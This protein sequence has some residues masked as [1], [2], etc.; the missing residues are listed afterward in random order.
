MTFILYQ[1]R[2]RRRPV[3]GVAPDP[4]TSSVLA[5]TPI[6]EDI[7]VAVLTAVARDAAGRPVV[8]VPVIFMAS[9]SGNT[10]TQS[11]RPTDVNGVVT[12][13]FESSVA[14]VKT[15][16]AIAGGVLLVATATVVVQDT[17]VASGPLGI[18][19]L[20]PPL[21]LPARAQP[22]P[23]VVQGTVAPGGADLLIET[24]ADSNFASRDWYDIDTTDRVASPAPAGMPGSMR[25]TWA[26]GNSSPSTLPLRKLFTASDRIYLRYQLQCSANWVG[27]GVSFHPHLMTIQSDADDDFNG[28][29]DANLSVYSEPWFS[30][31]NGNCLRGIFQD[32]RVIDP[33]HV[34]SLGADQNRSTSGANGQQ[35]D[36]DIWDVFPDAA[37]SQGYWN[38]RE[39]LS[40]ALMAVG[41]TAWHTVVMEVVLNSIS[42][43]A[44]LLD[45]VCRAWFDGKLIWNHTN[46][47]MRTG[48]QPT[49]KLNQFM[50]NPYIEG[51]SPVTQSLY[52]GDLTVRTGPGAVTNLAVSTQP[53]GAVD[54]V[55][56]TTQPT[57]QLRDAANRPVPQS[58]TTITA[59]LLSGSGA[60]I[61]T[62]TAVTNSGGEAAFTNLGV[63]ATSPPSSHTLRF[64][65]GAMTVDSSS[66][67]VAAGGGGGAVWLGNLPGS[68]AQYTSRPFSAIDELSWADDSEVSSPTLTSDA[69]APQ[70]PS[71]VGLFTYGAGFGAGSAPWL[72]AFALPGGKGLFTTFWAWW[73]SNFQGESS[74][75]NKIIFTDSSSTGTAGET[76]LSA[77]GVGS[78]QLV[79]RPRLQNGLDA[80]EHLTTN[81]GGSDVLTR[82]QWHLIE[83]EQIIGTGANGTW[84]AWLNGALTHSYTNVNYGTGVWETL[85]VYPIWGGTGGSVGSSQ[86]LRIDQLAAFGNA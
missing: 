63:N 62:A 49:K 22:R 86:N 11:V 74:G 20:P 26:A 45:G 32:N 70:S 19:R 38:S 68:Y 10:I 83:I 65:A 5:Q 8:G 40:S 81:Q 79:L 51:G 44:P 36:A 7:G 75:T 2:G 4:L 17:Y 52:V 28:P 77:E 73:S 54:N 46:L 56:F 76:F 35:G 31:G 61:G 53:A 42:G 67:S 60:L 24:F 64:T 39:F 15:I 3:I 13:L 84:R 55:A 66:F 27:S 14:A 30:A 57:I 23:R 50:F 33:T 47:V 16:S 12:A 43:G 48:S 58:G 71:S 34:G 78:G 25:F 69:S 6:V 37:Y 59:T 72:G 82:N 29:S 41:D 18:R 85:Y 21:I 80:R 1:G 9:G